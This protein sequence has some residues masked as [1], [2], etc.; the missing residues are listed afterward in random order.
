M[1][2]KEGEGKIKKLSF[3]EGK[4]DIVFL[5]FV[6]V[7]LTLGLVMLFSA[8]Y[9]YSY[10][11]Y[12]NS[13][14][15]ILRQT[16][17]AAVGLV[18]MF[19][20]SRI[21]Y[22]F[23]KKFSWV[24]Y[25]VCLAMLV[26][27]LIMPPMVQGMDVK[28]WLAIG[29]FSF[30]PSEI[31]KFS[32]ILL[33]SH[34]ISVNY[35]LMDKFKFILFLVAL[36]AVVCAL[37]VLE[38]HISAT[39]LILAI[40]VVLMIV[41]GLSWKYII[42]GGISV[43]VLGLAAYFSGI[44]GYGSDR[45]KYWLDPWADAKGLGYQT[46]QSLLAIG[47]GG[48]MGRGIGQSR[49]KYLWV[50]EPHNDFIFSIVCEELG[51]I[52]ATVIILLFCALVWRGFSIALKAPD[53]FGSLLAVGLTFQVGLQAI[54]NI[55]VVTNTIPNTGISLPFF[56]YGGTSLVILLAQ[57]GIVLSISRQSSIQKL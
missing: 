18:A 25:A 26:F 2:R 8:S 38:P 54:L 33:F 48:I 16:A 34:L 52:G 3:K 29:S 45:I 14:H 19:F 1:A 9:A 31:A 39:L 42:G 44:I 12:D 30:Q 40:G 41:G 15:F 51:L 56:S 28:R 47:S 24:L 46:I 11:Y 32:V 22:H 43:A 20:T 7:L 37:V 27:L 4:I 36:L 21:D 23:Y 49:Q 55:L 50:P 5:S 13:F 35:K 6:L 17:F 53:K 57:M 10:T